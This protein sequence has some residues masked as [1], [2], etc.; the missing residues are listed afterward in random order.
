MCASGMYD[1]EP[2]RRSYRNDYLHLTDELVEIL[3]P[4][5]LVDRLSAPVIV[6]FG[7]YE[8]REFQR[9]ARDFASAIETVGKPVRL[10]PGPGFNHFEIIV[11]LADP[12]GLLGFAALEQMGLA[13]G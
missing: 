9:Q 4:Q 10:L 12:F 1:L 5:R 6:A 11:S 3:S 2:V 8:T 7:S 13:P